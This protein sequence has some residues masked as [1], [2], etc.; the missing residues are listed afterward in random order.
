MNPPSILIVAGEKSGEN[1]GAAVV[2]AFRALNPEAKFFGVGGTNM[3]AAG[4]EVL[5]PMEDLAVMGLAEIIGDIPRIRRILRRL[6]AEARVRRPAAAVL[7]DSPD[8]NLRL[9]R[10][11]KKIGVPV[12]YYISPTVWAWR[13][14]RLKTIR[15][16][17]RKMLLIFPFEREIYARAEIPHRYVGHPLLERLQVRFS[18]EEFIRKYGLDPARPVITLMPGS[19]KNEILRHIT[20]LRDAAA[21]LKEE[22]G[23][24]FVLLQAGDLDPDFLPRLLSG[25]EADIRLLTTDAYEAVASSDL[26]LSACGTANLEA[27]LLGTPLIAFYKI[28]PL[29]YA[30]GRPF[31]RIKDYSIVNILAGRRI[32]PEL[33]QRRM[34]AAALVRETGRILDDADARREMMTVFARIRS[35]LG[36]ERASENAARELAALL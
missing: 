33:I 24:Q 3:T 19:R 1:Y 13:K 28:S 25:T 23:A 31:V 12:L 26:V 30:V 5:V 2:R 35:E 22:R 20:V 8:F 32:V 36:T 7:I 14:R 4:V 9:A 21:R 27:A 11:L 6:E 18:R 16:V 34:T 29:T 17:V 15:S 10:R